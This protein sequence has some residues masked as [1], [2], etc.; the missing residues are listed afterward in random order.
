MTFN[1]IKYFVTV[2]ECLSFTEAAKCLFITQPAL[3]R[4]ISAMEQ[5]LGTKLFVRDKK[6]LK[7]TP[8]GSVLY[9]R[10]LHLLTDYEEAV[11]EARHANSGYEGNLHIGFLDIYD[12]SGLFDDVIREFREAYENIEM[13]L[14]QFSL[15][16]LPERLYARD[17]DLILTYGFSLY[18]KPDLMTVNIQKFDSCIMLNRNHPLAAQETISLADLKEERFIQLGPKASEEGYRYITNLCVRC[19]LHPNIFPVE[20]ME[21]VMLWVQTGNGVAI[22]T[23][24]SIE[25]QN[26][27]VVIRDI[28]V[29]EAKNHNIT[30]A[31]CKNNYNP[32]I[33]IFME[34]LE[35]KLTKIL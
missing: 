18:D 7:L 4:Q 33:A 11:E 15:K 22:T 2:A 6:R 17:L 23:N 5:E 16:E 1:Q 12:I 34:M 9:N 27:H 19:G 25:K 35:K 10:L 8:G 30:M 13:S 31:W 20:K 14:E 3:S 29:P 32:A 28:D 21:D 26:P 24:R